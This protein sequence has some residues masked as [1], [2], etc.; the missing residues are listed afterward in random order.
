MLRSGPGLRPP[1]KGSL[2]WPGTQNH[3]PQDKNRNEN[4]NF[5]PADTWRNFWSHL[6]V[7]ACRGL[8]LALP[9]LSSYTTMAQPSFF[10]FTFCFEMGFHK[11]R[12]TLS[13]LEPKLA[14]TLQFSCLSLLRIE[15]IELCLHDWCKR[16]IHR[17]LSWQ[18][19][20]L[21]LWN[22][23]KHSAR[24]SQGPTVWYPA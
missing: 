12:L 14:F 23:H 15:L 8:A 13:S 2:A 5:L 24:V 9:R 3:L 10:Y 4:S 6:K 22:H 16:F 18:L 11:D 20:W 19:S 21:V 17:C 7:L 1:W